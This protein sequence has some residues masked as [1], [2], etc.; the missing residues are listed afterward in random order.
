MLVF[1]DRGQPE[2]PEKNLSEQRREP[3]T[4]STNIWCRR[5]DLNP[6]HISE[7]RVLSPLRHPCSSKLR[8]CYMRRFAT[9]I[10]SATLGCNIV[11]TLFQIVATL[12]QHCNDVLRWKWSLRIVPCNVTFG[13]TWCEFFKKRDQAK[14]TSLK[15]YFLKFFVV[16]QTNGILISFLTLEKLHWLPVGWLAK[17]SL[18]QTQAT[19]LGFPTPTSAEST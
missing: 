12:F 3:T 1:E 9:T 11:A 5:R 15:L 19:C 10:F 17:V 14:S 18:R 6:G 16:S 7:R 2:Y 4:N 13:C 8:W